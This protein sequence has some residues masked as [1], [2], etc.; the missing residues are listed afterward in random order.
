MKHPKL[1]VVVLAL[2]PCAASAATIAV[3]LAGGA[4]FTSVQA[5]VDAARDGDT[6]LVRPGEYALEEPLDF[7][8]AFRPGD[9]SGPVPKNLTLRAELGPERTTLR[10]F[11]TPPTPV[12]EAGD[13]H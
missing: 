13:S 9:L 12:L 3:D 1:L 6:V 4:D 11:P 2:V 7:N 8:H 10:L 5:A